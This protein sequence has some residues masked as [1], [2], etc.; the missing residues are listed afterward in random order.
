MRTTKDGKLIIIDDRTFTVKACDAYVENQ[1]MATIQIASLMQ[2]NY[3][4]PTDSVSVTI[5]AKDGSK[6]A[7][8]GSGVT[9]T[10]TRG[11][12]KVTAVA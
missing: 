1:M 8:I 2:W 3:E 11:L 6:V 5:S 9:F 10:P 7:L 12:M 4:G